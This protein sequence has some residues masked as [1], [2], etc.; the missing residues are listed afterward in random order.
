MGDSPAL[1]TTK[2]EQQCLRRLWTDEKS[3][4]HNHKCGDAEDGH[5]D[6]YGMSGGP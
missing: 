3:D 1:D 5:D 2:G 4:A 6:R